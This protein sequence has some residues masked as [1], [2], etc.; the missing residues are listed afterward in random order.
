[1]SRW[2]LFTFTFFAV[3]AEILLKKKLVKK[4]DLAILF[5]PLFLGKKMSNDP[6]FFDPFKARNILFSF[7]I[8]IL[9]IAKMAQR[10]AIG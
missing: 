7:S 6:R 9:P 1:M 10:S 5:R 8:V 2:H 3:P 4:F